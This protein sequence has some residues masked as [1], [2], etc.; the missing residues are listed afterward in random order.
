MATL[1]L[2]RAMPKGTPLEVSFRL[3]PDGLLSLHG[4]EQ[5]TGRE[6]KADFKT[7]SIMSREEVE[8]AKSRNLSLRVA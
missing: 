7:E 2:G 4:T 8:E 3:G 6:I 1:E 5:T